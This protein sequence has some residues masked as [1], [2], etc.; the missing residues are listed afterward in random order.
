MMLAYCSSET[1]Q[2][3]PPL[4]VGRLL[5]GIL[6]GLLL[7]LLVELLV[8]EPQ[9]NPH[10]KSWQ[11][12][13]AYSQY[14]EH[15]KKLWPRIRTKNRQRRRMKTE[16]RRRRNSPLELQQSCLKAT[17]HGSDVACPD[18]ACCRQHCD[19]AGLGAVYGAT[20]WRTWGRPRG[21]RHAVKSAR[22]LGPA[23][24]RRW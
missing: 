12:H 5:V 20:V 16:T 1:I 22:S 11:I 8:V 6:Q 19:L 10:G 23:R 3:A 24:W 2:E 15:E 14:E 4:L 18:F 21:A 17:S 9:L 7:G 13:W